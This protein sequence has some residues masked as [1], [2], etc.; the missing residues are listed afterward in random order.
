MT[1]HSLFGKVQE[2]WAG[3]SAEIFFWHPFFED[4]KAEIFLGDEFDEDGEEIDEPPSDEDLN[5]YAETY[6]RF[7]NLFDVIL[8]DL[9]QKAFER[10]QKLYAHYYE[11]TE[12]SGEPPL[13]IDSVEKHNPFIKELNDI[14][15]SKN[16]TIRLSL[17]YQL[18]TEHGLEFKFIDNQIDAIA[19]IAE[20]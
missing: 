10:Y 11:N 3:F 8:L 5:I 18:D 12:K 2:D 9:Q 19:G 13:N 16:N 1:Q 6:Q 20:T 7:I 15:I 4:N 14:R 17:H